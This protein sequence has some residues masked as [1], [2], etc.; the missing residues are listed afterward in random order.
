MLSEASHL[1]AHGLQSMRKKGA[2][3]AVSQIIQTCCRINANHTLV[4]QRNANFVA[5]A[6]LGASYIAELYL[7]KRKRIVV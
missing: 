2:S 6:T 7:N 4:T 3:T 1:W 5:V